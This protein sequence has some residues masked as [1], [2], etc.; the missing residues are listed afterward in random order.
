MQQLHLTTQRFLAGFWNLRQKLFRVLGKKLRGN[1]GLEFGHVQVLRYISQ[2]DMTPSEL[3]EEM[4]IPAHGISRMLE[5]LE[6]QGLLERKLNPTD[7]RKRSLTLTKKGTTVL[8]ASD[9]V[10]ETEV[11]AIIGALP[12]KDLGQFL[13]YLEKLTKE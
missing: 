12:K 4:Q 13:N 8:K 1:F 6:T 5:C 2:T 9:A 11:K 3:A 7:A 10:I